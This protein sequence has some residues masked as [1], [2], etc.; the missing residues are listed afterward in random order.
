MNI[1][2]NLMEFKHFHFGHM[3]FD[4]TYKEGD[5][6]NEDYYTCHYNNPVYELK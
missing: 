1:V 3:H 5:E 2:D 4:H 6:G